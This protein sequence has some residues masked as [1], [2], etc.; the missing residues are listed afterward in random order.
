MRTFHHSMT[1]IQIPIVES[2]RGRNLIHCATDYNMDFT[3]EQ[4]VISA[5]GSLDA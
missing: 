2:T 4:Y 5:S 1:S 3:A